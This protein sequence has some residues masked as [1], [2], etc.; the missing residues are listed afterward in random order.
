MTTL[1]P[2]KVI[3]SLIIPTEIMPNFSQILEFDFY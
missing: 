2:K 1:P 3:F